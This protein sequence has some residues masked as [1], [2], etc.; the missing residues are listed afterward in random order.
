MI[1]FSAPLPTPTIM[2]VGVASPSAQGQ[3]I[4]STVAEAISPREKPLTASSATQ[5]YVAE[6]FQLRFYDHYAA[7]ANHV[8]DIQLHNRLF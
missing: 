5:G 6:F 4:T 7:I 3:A 2:A 1:P 8:F